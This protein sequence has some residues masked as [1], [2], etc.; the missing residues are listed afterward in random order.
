MGVGAL[1]WR[2][3]LGAE[4]SVGEGHAGGPICGGWARNREAT[5]EVPLLSN[6]GNWTY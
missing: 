4:T 6:L 5:T 3:G 2:A 1:G